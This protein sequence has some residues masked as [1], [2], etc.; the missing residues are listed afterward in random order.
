MNGSKTEKSRVVV[1][2]NVIFMALYNENSKAGKIIEYANKDKIELFSPDSVKE[3]LINVLKREMELSDNEIALI[4]ESFPITW[5]ERL[6]YE[7]FLKQTRVKHK[8][9]KPVEAV[10]LILGCGILTADKHF[11][12]RIDVNKLLEKLGK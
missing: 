5:V 11:K 9:D 3:E 1:D 4:M 2:T 8:A 6:I 7:K 12:N 10:S